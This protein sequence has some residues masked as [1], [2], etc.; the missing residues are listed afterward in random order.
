MP[1]RYHI[2]Y[3]CDCRIINNAWRTGSNSP[4]IPWYSNACWTCGSCNKQRYVL[5]NSWSGLNSGTSYDPHG[6]TG[7]RIDA[8]K[9]GTLLYSG[10][11]QQGVFTQVLTGI[12]YT[13]DFKT[14]LET[15]SYLGN[16]HGTQDHASG[17]QCSGSGC[18]GTTLYKAPFTWTTGGPWSGAVKWGEQTYIYSEAW[19]ATGLADLGITCLVT[20]STTSSSLVWCLTVFSFSTFLGFRLLNWSTMSNR[21][22]KWPINKDKEGDGVTKRSHDCD[23][24]HVVQL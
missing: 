6:A 15:V 17:W 8:N 16:L 11:V 19:T 22:L 1:A 23:V 7:F 13:P 9:C 24:S 12:D 3:E 2:G 14:P 4:Q 10:V 20:V 21:K 5:D 18:S